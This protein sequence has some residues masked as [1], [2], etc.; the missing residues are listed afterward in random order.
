VKKRKTVRTAAKAAVGR[1]VKTGKKAGKK[2]A[3]S[4]FDAATGKF[5]SFNEAFTYASNQAA[6]G[7]ALVVL[8]ESVIRRMKDGDWA[9]AALP[10]AKAHNIIGA[11]VVSACEWGSSMF[12]SQTRGAEQP[13]GAEVQMPFEVLWRELLCIEDDPLSVSGQGFLDALGR[14]PMLEE[15]MAYCVNYLTE[16]LT[17]R[18]EE[19][20]EH[21]ALL[22][23]LVDEHVWAGARLEYVLSR[24]V[25]ELKDRL[26]KVSQLLVI[27][28]PAGL[29]H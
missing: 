3:D 17:G 28:E 23:D 13:S 7:T 2:P 22:K 5:H 1:P 14:T 18:F 12:A 25:P 11:L 10:F 8:E 21:Q 27:S 4:D 15:L 24:F 29:V 19:L 26:E 16:I 6:F 9:L 20:K